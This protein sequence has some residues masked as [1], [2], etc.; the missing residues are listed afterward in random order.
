MPGAEAVAQMTVY[1]K[2]ALIL[3]IVAIVIPIIQAIWK[4]WIVCAKLTYMPTG[5]GI[6]YFNQSGSYIR[7]DGV[8]G[9]EHKPVYIKKISAK[10]TRQKDERK[11]NL[12]WSSLISPVNQNMVGN[13]LQ[14]TESAHPFRIDADSVAC[15]FTEFADPYD[16]FGK[17][18]KLTTEPLFSKIQKYQQKQ[19]EYSAALSDYKNSPEYETA[20]QLAEKEFFWEIGKYDIDIEVLY[21]KKVKHFG[22]TFNVNEQEN[23]MLIQNIE[24]SLLSPLKDLYRIGRNYS[25]ALIE[26]QDSG[27]TANA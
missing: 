18:F 20:K 7:L 12:T 21:G 9:S 19:T 4:K 24:E 2:W 3:S 27:A 15:A 5:R 10:I 17:K 1:E 14:T 23:A 22:C 6:L 13:Y 8:Y 26:V 16:S 25:S 11:L